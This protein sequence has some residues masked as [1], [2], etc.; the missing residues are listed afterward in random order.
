VGTFLP[1]TSLGFESDRQRVEVY[2]Y[3]RRAPSIDRY[4]TAERP[5]R[6]SRLTEPLYYR[7]K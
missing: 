6:V 3:R 4:E 2:R 7:L 1:A 5:Y